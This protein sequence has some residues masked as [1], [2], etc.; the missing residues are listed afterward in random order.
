MSSKRTSTP[1][2]TA[3]AELQARRDDSADQQKALP[4]TGV[5]TVPPLWGADGLA[6]LADRADPRIG[7]VVKFVHGSFD[8]DDGSTVSGNRYVVLGATEEKK[9]FIESQTTP[10]SMPLSRS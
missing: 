6:L 1:A 9:V 5:V 7:T 4:A 8:T 2:D 3:F 10:K